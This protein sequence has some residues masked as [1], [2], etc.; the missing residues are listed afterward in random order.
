MAV[1]I[2]EDMRRDEL[3][4]RHFANARTWIILPWISLRLWWLERSI[5]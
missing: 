3:W 5:R 1:V 2:D 4:L